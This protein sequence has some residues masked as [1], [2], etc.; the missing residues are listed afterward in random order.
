LESRTNYSGFENFKSIDIEVRERLYKDIDKDT[1]AEQFFLDGSWPV[2]DYKTLLLNSFSSI[3]TPKLL[4]LSGGIDSEMLALSMIEAGAQFTPVI[5]HWTAVGKVVNS[6]DTE[7]AIRFCREH[8]LEPII[9]EF[10]IPALW[11]STE[12]YQLA[13]DVGIVSPQQITYAHA[14][15]ELDKEFPDHMHMF[16]GEVRYLSDV[17]AEDNRLADL[18][19]LAKVTPGYDTLGYSKSNSVGNPASVVLTYDATAGTWTIQFLGLGTNSGSPTSGSW[20]TTPGSAY[21][22]RNIDVDVLQNTDPPNVDIVPPSLDLTWY[23][24]TSVTTIASVAIDFGGGGNTVEVLFTI[25]VRATASPA[26]VVTTTIILQAQ[27]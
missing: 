8:N 7:Y 26:T 2:T 17:E 22:Y 14:V 3:D 23:S 21:E 19:M 9:R 10:N 15:L 12:F 4:Y 1:C 24:L 27:N 18:V 11:H 13:V 6:Y 16:G 5:L 20:T 25:D